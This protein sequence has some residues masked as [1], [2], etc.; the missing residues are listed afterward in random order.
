MANTN[1]AYTSKY[2]GEQIDTAVGAFLAGGYSVYATVNCKTDDWKSPKDKIVGPGKYFCQITIQ[3]VLGSVYPHVFAVMNENTY[4]RVHGESLE[5]GLV[6]V[7][8]YVVF[9]APV[10]N[11]VGNSIDVCLWS[12]VQITGTIV[13]I[14]SSNANSSATAT[15]K[16]N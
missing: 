14:G 12:N 1:T 8:P 10:P 2:T 6:V 9:K 3:N 5:S 4:Y 15:I 16:N 11:K 13:F 7:S